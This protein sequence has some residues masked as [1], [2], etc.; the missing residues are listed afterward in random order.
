MRRAAIGPEDGRMS[1]K[2]MVII[3]AALGGLAAAPAGAFWPRSQLMACSE[4]A[5]EADYRRWRCWE[6][7]GFAEA[8]VF[9]GRRAIDLDPGAAW[10][11]APRRRPQGGV[12][13][14]LG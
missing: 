1:T 5:N 4:V 9:F 6:L 10:R 11:H 3:L 12:V 7:D 13:R 14:R 2:A 8:P